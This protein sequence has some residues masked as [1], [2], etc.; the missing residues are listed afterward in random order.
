MKKMNLVGSMTC[1]RSTTTQ[2]QSRF[3]P[4]FTYLKANTPLDHNYPLKRLRDRFKSRLSCLWTHLLQD[5]YHSTYNSLT[6]WNINEE[7]LSASFKLG[8]AYWQ[9]KKRL[10]KA[11]LN[12]SPIDLYIFLYGSPSL[13]FIT[14][15]STKQDYAR[16]A[17][18]LVLF[19]TALS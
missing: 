14:R 9:V 1:P 17:Y 7:D 11:S 8:Q 12:M 16:L 6:D 18:S 19:R 4:R 10:E 2:W 5:I 13:F 15:I 3:N